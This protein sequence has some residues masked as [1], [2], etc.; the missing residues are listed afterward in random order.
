MFEETNEKNR[1]E[2]SPENKKENKKDLDKFFE[3]EE[4][5]IHTMPE[6]FLKVEER[7]KG[8]IL[9]IIGGVII[10]FFLVLGVIFIFVKG[11]HKKKIVSPPPAENQNVSLTNQN[12]NL[13][14]PLVSS[15]KIV[16]A[17][18]SNNKGEVISSIKLFFP[19]GALKKEEDI[20]L[21]PKMIEDNDLR[22][23]IVGGSYSLYPEEIEITKPVVLTFIYRH[24]L[25]KKDYEDKLVIVGYKNGFW[26]KIG[27]RVSPSENSIMIVLDKLSYHIYGLAIPR[28][29][30]EKKPSSFIKIGLPSSFD[31]DKD[32]LT[33]EEESIYQT[34]K[35]DPDTDRDSYP[36]GLE[37]VNLY[38]PLS[39]PG[40]RLS[41]SGLINT[42]TNPIYHYSV[43]Y[44]ST[45]LAKALPNTENR[46]V[47]FTSPTGE[48]IEII[49]QDNP[50]R[51]SA[52]DWYLEQLSS[53]DASKIT[54][55]KVNDLEGVWAIDGQTIYLSR[56]DKIYGL[57][58][59]FGGKKTLSFKSTFEMMIKSFRL[60][61]SAQA[62]VNKVSIEEL[63]NNPQNYYGKKI[64]LVGYVKELG[65]YHYQD[66]IKKRT[67]PTFAL[68]SEG[69]DEE[70]VKDKTKAI[71][72]VWYE[73]M[74]REDG[75]YKPKV[76][77]K[78]I[79]NNDLVKIIGEFKNKEKYAKA[80]DI[81]LESISKL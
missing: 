81:W 69:G 29:L 26:E 49:V 15:K 17:K 1:S 70:Y 46:Q 25:V 38:S 18:F 80:G 28:E 79:E 63:K 4:I 51:L 48:F 21:T 56:G 75:T 55:V 23:S 47:I 27:G 20:K 22:F 7:K 5:E 53:S 44:P 73:G 16:T 40:V 72:N 37:I 8:P 78:G 62:G 34:K 42:Y 11:G 50:R 65:E 6:K 13:N 12:A 3:E 24:D 52:L 64:E 36:D 2:D 59:N 10:I 74:R 66:Q 14:R 58:Y 76:E 68:S 71:E 39:G 67:T 9:F 77:I 61:G 54:K 43:F 33:D 41:V 45:F 31:Q 32:G 35:N 30:V 60:V 19:E 57:T